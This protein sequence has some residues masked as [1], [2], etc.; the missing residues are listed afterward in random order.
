MNPVPYGMVDNWVKK[1][2]FFSFLHPVETRSC[3]CCRVTETTEGSKLGY[4]CYPKIRTFT[5]DSSELPYG[6]TL[7]INCFEYLPSASR[8]D[9]LLSGTQHFVGSY[10][11]FVNFYRVLTAL[12]E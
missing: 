11:D 3:D 4:I 10:E 6:V 5:S 2:G 7:C 8:D 1:K 12:N 9:L